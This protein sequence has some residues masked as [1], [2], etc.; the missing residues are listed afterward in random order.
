MRWCDA[1]EPELAVVAP[2]RRG[3]APNEPL[4]KPDEAAAIHRSVLRPACPSADEEEEARVDPKVC[5]A[6]KRGQTRRWLGDAVGQLRPGAGRS[7]LARGLARASFV[8]PSPRCIRRRRTARA[9]RAPGWDA[10]K[11]AVLEA[12]GVAFEGDDFGVVDEAVPVA[13]GHP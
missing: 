8:P 7:C 3:A 9:R 4:T 10:A 12:V 2:E 1:T 11:V 6:E 13:G 5:H